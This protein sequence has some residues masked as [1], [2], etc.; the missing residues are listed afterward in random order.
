MSN[1]QGL[2]EDLGAFLHGLEVEENASQHTVKAYRTDLSHF[3]HFLDAWLSGRETDYRGG[4][5]DRQQAPTST[6]NCGSRIV[7]A[8]DI[9]TGAVRAWAA[10][11]HAASL[12]PVTI[13]RKL[14]AVRS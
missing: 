13:G 1:D 10:R 8:T 3:G 4:A 7:K 12:S 5:P 6:E 9:D 2:L 14:A 11:M